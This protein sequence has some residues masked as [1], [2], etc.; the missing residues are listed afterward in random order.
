MGPLG[1]IEMWMSQVPLL[2]NLEPAKRLQLAGDLQ[3]KAAPHG[4]EI[5]HQ[6]DRGDSMFIIEEG[7]CSR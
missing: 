1:R 2:S 7:E 6:G 4:V 3:R 5:M